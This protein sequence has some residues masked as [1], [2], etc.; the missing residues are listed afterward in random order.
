MTPSSS[1]RRYIFDLRPSVG[2][3]PSL[4]TELR[5][6]VTELSEPYGVE[7]G[8]DVDCPPTY[9]RTPI[10]LILTSRS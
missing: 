9:A 6:P 5:R 8:V 4:S 1:L 7:V 3:W 2:A 10:A